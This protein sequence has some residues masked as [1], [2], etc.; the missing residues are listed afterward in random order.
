MLTH[1]LWSIHY[2]AQ[3]ITGW[4]PWTH[5][6][7][8]GRGS[9]SPLSPQILSY[10]FQL[11]HPTSRTFYRNRKCPESMNYYFGL[12]IFKDMLEARCKVK[13]GNN[14]CFL[15]LFL[16]FLSMGSEVTHSACFSHSAY[17]ECCKASW[18][19]AMC[20]ELKPNTKADKPNSSQNVS[21]MRTGIAVCF[22]HSS[23]QSSYNIT[24]DIVDAQYILVEW[25]NSA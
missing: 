20:G 7:P 22:I 3:F 24:W 18:D 25:V 1:F 13:R 5:P 15:V 12:E 2:T 6:G 4:R 8:W 23:V 17:L 10:S 21:S 19:I 14:F 16:T 9:H 11:V